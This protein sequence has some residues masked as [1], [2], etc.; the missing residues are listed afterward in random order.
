M[1]F[2]SKLGKLDPIGSK[3]H[4]ID[5][6]GKYDIVGNAIYGSGGRTATGNGLGQLAPTVSGWTPE[7]QE[8]HD[9]YAKAED[10]SIGVGKGIQSEAGWNPG[11]MTEGQILDQFGGGYGGVTPNAGGP[12]TRGMYGSGSFGQLSGRMA[13]GMSTGYPA[14]SVGTGAMMSPDMRYNQR[15]MN[16][17]G[18][19]ATS[20]YQPAAQEYDR[21]GYLRR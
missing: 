10:T 2:L 19:W 4:K 8:L 5:P 18:R 14:Q 21:S 9:Y 20:G 7:M 12:A 11:M 16:D 13:P 1:G 17:L 6:F 3:L 15:P